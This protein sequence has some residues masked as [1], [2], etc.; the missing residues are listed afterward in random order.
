[1]RHLSALPLR[2]GSGAPTAD[3]GGSS[4]IIMS[5]MR[6]AHAVRISLIYGSRLLLTAR[7]PPSG[8]LLFSYVKL[9]SKVRIG[10]HRCASV[11]EGDEQ[12]T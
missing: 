6:K 10:A 5:A 1:M 3:R 2:C 9:V 7:G 12:T 11:P 4:C 8:R